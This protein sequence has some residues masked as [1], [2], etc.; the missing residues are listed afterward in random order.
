MCAERPAHILLADDDRGTCEL[1]AQ[2]LEPLGLEIR[3]VYSARDA[4]NA[5]TAEA[6]E[7]VLLDY[8]LPGT[9]ALELIAELDRLGSKVPPFIVV[10]GHGDETVAVD[11]MK[12]GAID[13]IIKNAYFLDNL[14]PAVKK[15][16]EK[17]ALMREL[18]A[19]QESTVKNLRLYT[20]LAQ[21]NQASAQIKDRKGLLSRICE[22]LVETGGFMFSCAG[23]PDKDTGRLAPFCS[24]CARPG[25]SDVSK[26]YADALCRSIIPATAEDIKVFQDIE[27]Q[28]LGASWRD[29]A[30]AIGCRSAAIVPLH[31]KEEMFALLSVY[32]GEKNM[33]SEDEVSLLQEIR[34]DISFAIGTISAEEERSS[35]KAALERTATELSRIMEVA[36]VIL[37][38]LRFVNGRLV[39]QWVSGNSRELLGYDAEE[40]LSPGWFQA[41]LHPDDRGTVLQEQGR[42]LMTG[43]LIQDFRV[44]KKDG[45]GYAWVHSHLKASP[46]RQD[47]ITGSWMATSLP[48]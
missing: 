36:P 12:A 30:L 35:A 42:I 27:A 40:L 23:L 1:E 28:N 8:A 10:T 48:N 37:F 38:T 17:I 21:V 19:A 46:G 11:A 34:R 14:L 39:T 9:S 13:Y 44:L 31:D 5:I 43:N 25:G 33:F 32:S 15:A 4:I 3:R 2:H 7:L 6:P 20:I 26:S 24:S 47:E 41:A 18:S 16:L 22:I 45:S 29:K